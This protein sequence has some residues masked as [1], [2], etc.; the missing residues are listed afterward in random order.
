MYKNMFFT[1]IIAFP[2]QS[3]ADPPPL[4]YVAQALAVL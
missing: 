3:A 4:V 2:A 1:M